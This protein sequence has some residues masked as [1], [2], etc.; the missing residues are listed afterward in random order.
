MGKNNKT[1]IFRLILY[2]LYQR[3]QKPSFLLEGYDQENFVS[4]IVIIYS[5]HRALQNRLW[6]IVRIIFNKF[7][8]KK[9]IF[10]I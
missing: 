10:A 2:F 5:A 9:T 4:F 8:F 6:F 3:N 1:L 7:G